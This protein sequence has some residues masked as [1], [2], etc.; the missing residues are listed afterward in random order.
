MCKLLPFFSPLSS[1]SS[2]I[3]L[4]PHLLLFLHTQPLPPG[5]PIYIAT[6][7]Y[8]VVKSHK[9]KN[10]MMIIMNTHS[11]Y[12]VVFSLWFLLSTRKLTVHRVSE[13]PENEGFWKNE[14][15]W[16]LEFLFQPNNSSWLEASDIPLNFKTSPLADRLCRLAEWHMHP[17]SAGTVIRYSWP[18]EPV[19]QFC[20]FILFY[21][22]AIFS[23]SKKIK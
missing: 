19:V 23:K 18:I 16:G 20:F 8:Y 17:I 6:R 5:R 14:C 11:I 13:F 2:T 21:F 1:S 12:S 4:L 3:R 10:M 7:P 9:E 22:D 15:F